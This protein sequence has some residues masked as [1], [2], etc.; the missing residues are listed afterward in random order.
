[1][2]SPEE[3]RASQRGLRSVSSFPFARAPLWALAATVTGSPDRQRASTLDRDSR[4]T[5]V[6]GPTCSRGGG[7]GAIEAAVS[8]LRCPHVR[9]PQPFMSGGPA[10]RRAGG[11]GSPAVSLS[12]YSE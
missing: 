5:A 11:E 2:T 4:Q 8:A 7:G 3:P 1:L 9:L 10:A 6:A 12:G